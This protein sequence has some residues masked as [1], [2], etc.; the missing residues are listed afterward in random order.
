M[1]R[2]NIN[3]SGLAIFHDFISLYSAVVFWTMKA[4]A[5]GCQLGSTM[6]SFNTMVLS[7]KV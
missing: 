2:H 6:L 7:K 4:V 1:I 3:M 5:V